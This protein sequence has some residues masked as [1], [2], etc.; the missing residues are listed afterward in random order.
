MG[1]AL[2]T[3]L[4]EY[5]ISHDLMSKTWWDILANGVKWLKANESVLTDAHWIGGDPGSGHDIQ[6]RGNEPKD[7]YGFASLGA[8]KGI[9]ILRNPSD[10]AQSIDVNL[11]A[12][13]ETPKARRAATFT[14]TMI[15]NS[16]TAYENAGK[17]G[18]FQPIWP[19][20]TADTV[21]WTLPPFATIL[22]EIA[23]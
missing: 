10:K 2:G 3:G 17:P 6:K 19:A 7:I 23:E 18:A 11:D 12:L 16:T 15:F 9:V 8:K 21:T 1:V 14:P 22:F 5:Y 13:L 4:Q 20:T